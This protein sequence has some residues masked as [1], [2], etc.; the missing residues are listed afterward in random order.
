MPSPFTPPVTPASQ[1]LDLGDIS[2]RRL[3]EYD[4]ALHPP[5]VPGVMYCTESVSY[6]PVRA[7]LTLSVPVTRDVIELLL[8][9]V[10][11][12]VHTANGETIT[13]CVT[14]GAARFGGVAASVTFVDVVILDAPSR[15]EKSVP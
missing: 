15:S 8:E 12:A 13:Q 7:N 2:G 4:P 3:Q 9:L 5:S 6:T 10:P 14:P 11:T 1:V